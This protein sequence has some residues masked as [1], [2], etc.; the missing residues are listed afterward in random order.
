M[1][2][3][4]D[5]NPDIYLTVPPQKGERKPG[6][7]TNAQLKQYFE[8]GCLLVPDFFKPEELDPVR[9]GVKSSVDDIVNKLYDA[10]K[11]KDKY[12]NVDLFQRMTC[13]EKEFPG[14]AVLLHKTGSLPRSFKDLWSDARLL[15]VME[16]LIGPNIAGHPVWNLRV[17]TPQNEEAVVPWHQ[18]NA[19][20]D[21]SALNVLQVTAWIPLLDVTAKNGCMQ[22][23]RKGHRKGVT[24]K[25]RCCVGGTWYV[26]VEVEDM[27]ET[28]GVDMDKDL[29]TCD[30]SYGGV[31]FMNN[32]VPHRSLTNLSNNIR[33]SLD[34][35]WQRPDKPNGF[36]GIKD[37]VLMR[38]EGD[39][40]YK[41][42][43]DEFESTDHHSVAKVIKDP[44]VEIKSD[45][46]DFDTTIT[47][48]WM[49]RWELVFH[50]RH[51]QNFKPDDEFNWVKA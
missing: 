33:W 28:L 48:P 44:N 23:A 37:S 17:K 29:V 31:L 27:V 50:N 14:A 38:T 24:A 4:Q 19:Y 47:G 41:P 49:Q 46:V 18:D 20:L 15:N 22:V 45:D 42:N 21:P 8:E 26:E 40:N 43:W 9:E 12:E 35:R 7:L 36:Y 2:D 3:I 51:T 11:I 16:Q 1:A 10:G 30:M 25:H 13:V 34:L 5:S 6:Q 39:P 32:C